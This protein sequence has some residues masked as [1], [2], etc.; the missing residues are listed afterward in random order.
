M[1]R[2]LVVDD[3]PQVREAL[4]LALEDEF[5]VNA[6]ASAEDAFAQLYLVR[7]DAMILD[8]NMAGLNGTGLLGLLDA[9]SLAPPVIMLC[10]DPDVRLARKALGLGAE[11]VLAKPFDVAVLKERLRRVS[12][13]RRARNEEEAPLALRGAWAAERCMD[14]GGSLE[15]RTGRF[16]KALIAEAVAECWGDRGLAARML[17]VSV[18]EMGALQAGFDASLPH[19]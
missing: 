6:A 16:G 5:T 4:R 10:G 12:N 14:S 9:E 7:P 11:D 18:P 8:Q 3:E 17:Q 1:F 13:R 19:S 2:V 15:E